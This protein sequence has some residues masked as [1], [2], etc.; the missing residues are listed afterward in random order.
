MK[1]VINT[2]YGGFSLSPEANLWLYK[3]GYNEEGFITPVEK[4]FTNTESADKALKD[5]EDYLRTGKKQFVIFPFTLDKKYLLYSRDINRTHPLLIKCI[6]ELDEKANGQFAKLKIVEI[7][8]GVE[9]TIEDY[10]GIE[11]IAEVHSTW[12]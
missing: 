6:E 9:Y 2:C 4:Y 1:I 3:H 10:D 7:P 8:D 5:W 12:S 11:H